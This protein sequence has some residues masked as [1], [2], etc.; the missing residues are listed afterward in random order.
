MMHDNSEP[1]QSSSAVED[2]EKPHDSYSK[3]LRLPDGATPHIAIWGTPQSGKSVFLAMLYAS[4][5]NTMRSET[6]IE[7]EWTMR[8]TPAADDWV[9]SIYK[10]LEVQGIFPPA[11]GLGDHYFPVFT[12]SDKKT[13]A[14]LF[15]FTFIDAPGEMYA[16]PDKYVTDQ[17]INVHPYDYLAKCDGL[18]LLVD[19]IEAIEG[20]FNQTYTAL[21]SMFRSLSHRTGGGRIPLSMALCITKCDDIRCRS[22]FDNPRAFA[23]NHFPQFV[24]LLPTYVAEDSYEWFAC[25]A[26][27]YEK[28]KSAN[29][30][31]RWN[32]EWGIL[33]LNK[34][35]SHYIVDA[36]M[37]LQA[38]STTK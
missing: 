34:L 38:N 30:I 26:I 3:A 25:S 4:L 24:G 28:N 21:E 7:V 2:V 10:K 1:S 14:R 36:L 5:S 31:R 27:G 33:D 35:K 9:E 18:L 20:N 12:V 6:P 15:T 8:A 23:K 22:A 19:P 32:G 37:W 29:I 13:D 11:T 16:N 17:K